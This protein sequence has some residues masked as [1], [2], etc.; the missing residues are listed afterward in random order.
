MG[1]ALA[2]LAGCARHAVARVQSAHG[3]EFRC[4]PRYVRV[5]RASANHWISRGC[6]FEADWTCQHRA[7]QL[8]D[9]RAHGVGAP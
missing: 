4:D 8:D 7:C 2:L 3:Q 5:E 9:S 6:G 1:L